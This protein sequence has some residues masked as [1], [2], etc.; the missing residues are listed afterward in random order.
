MTTT[1]DRRDIDDALDLWGA[2]APWFDATGADD[3]GAL[4][5]VL[6]ALANARAVDLLARLL[7][8][9]GARTSDGVTLTAQLTA[10]W[11]RDPQTQGL[12]VAHLPHTDGACPTC[13][14]V[15]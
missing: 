12:E 10:E 9:H 3:D 11:L 1:Y 13:E 14:G 2:I 15:R 4:V 8:T 6:A 5:R 7:A